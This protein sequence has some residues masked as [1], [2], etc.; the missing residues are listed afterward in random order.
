MGRKKPKI[1]LTKD[2]V[3]NL[4]NKDRAYTILC[5][6]LG[7]GGREA[8][9]KLMSLVK[10]EKAIRGTL[11]TNDDL[12]VIADDLAKATNHVCAISTGLDHILDQL[13]ATG[14]YPDD[15]DDKI[16]RITHEIRTQASQ[17]VTEDRKLQRKHD[18]E[19]EKYKNR[20][21]NLKRALQSSMATNSHLGSI[22]GIYHDDEGK[23][24][25]DE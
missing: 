2:F 20:N 14:I 10:F 1:T 23:D 4:K 18:G 13:C 21:R 6:I 12:S 15:I 9:E 17:R 7:C 11:E 8:S 3:E 22:M 25:S 19:K 16:E 5:S 24:K